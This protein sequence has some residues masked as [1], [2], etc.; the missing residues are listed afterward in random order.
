MCHVLREPKKGGPTSDSGLPRPTFVDPGHLADKG[1]ALIVDQCRQ[2]HTFIGDQT[3]RLQV[4][5]DAMLRRQAT[6][7]P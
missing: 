3:W 5:H 6:T 7:K 2:R 1:V 4:R